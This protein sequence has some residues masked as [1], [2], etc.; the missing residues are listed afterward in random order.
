M[1]SVLLSDID[2]TDEAFPSADEMRL[3]C[4]KTAFYLQGLKNGAAIELKRLKHHPQVSSFTLEW[5]ALADDAS[6]EAMDLF[7]AFMRNKA[8]THTPDDAKRI[9]TF[10]YRPIEGNLKH[11]PPK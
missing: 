1:A 4:T 10:G 3:G 2:V 11:T 8:F 6:R 5:N 9:H 7:V